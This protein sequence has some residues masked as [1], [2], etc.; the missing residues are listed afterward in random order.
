M[1]KTVEDIGIYTDIYRT[2]QNDNKG[3]VLYHAKCKVCDQV[4]YYPLRNIRENNKQCRHVKNDLNQD[5]GIYTNV[6]ESGHKTNDGHK[7]YNATCKICGAVV[8]KMLSDIKRNNTICYHKKGYIQLTTGKINDMP[9]GWMTSSKINQKTYYTWKAMLNR[10]TEKYWEQYPSYTGTT[11][12]DRWRILSNFVNDIKD[13][14]GYDD[15]KT[16]TNRQMMLDKDTIIEGN[17]HYSKDTCRFITHTESNQDVSRRH[18]ENIRKAQDA[19]KNNSSEP[20]RFTNTETKTTIDFPSL[21]E[22]CRTLKLN[23]FNAWSVLS[24]KYPDRNAI[25]GWTIS[26]I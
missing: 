8:E 2:S 24:D 14:D 13:L 15:W 25:K 16:S 3:N 9:E 11:V 17:K 1:E 4:L 18:P 21:K 7:L 10:T 26:K 12:D 20:V 22:G 6:H 5:F 19:S 23:V